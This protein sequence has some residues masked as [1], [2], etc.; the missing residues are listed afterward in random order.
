MFTSP[1]FN[2][3]SNS[4]ENSNKLHSLRFIPALIPL[5]SKTKLSS[6]SSNFN[7]MRLSVYIYITYLAAHET[8]RQRIHTILY[9]LELQMVEPKVDCDCG[10]SG[11]KWFHTSI[12]KSVIAKCAR[13]QKLPTKCFG[14]QREKC[15]LRSGVSALI[16]R[17]NQPITQI[18]HRKHWCITSF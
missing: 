7:N 13:H 14:L 10:S 11:L 17:S 6:T 16:Y 3:I 5:M 18:S 2:T 1:F 9:R 8:D 15:H 4:A 12:A